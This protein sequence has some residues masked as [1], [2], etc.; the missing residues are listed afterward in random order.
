M[1][2]A[3]PK[4][5]IDAAIDAS[6]YLHGVRKDPGRALRIIERYAACEFVAGA[7]AEQ[8]L[9]VRSIICAVIADCYRE[10]GDVKVAAEWYRSA[11][12]SW[13]VGGFPAFYADMVITHELADHYETALECL[14]VN[15][16]SWRSRPL[17]VRWYYN[18]ACCWWLYPAMWRL[19]LRERSFIPRL[20]TLI[21]DRVTS[22]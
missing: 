15:D 11:S 5:A 8:A 9:R 10:L 7:G 22:G 18:I 17:L 13:R 14:K 21:K 19:R 2:T 1:T 4:Q 16:E 6:R 12:Q 20:E 3:T